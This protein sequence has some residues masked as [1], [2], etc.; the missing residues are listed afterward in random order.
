MKYRRVPLLGLCLVLLSLAGKATADALPPLTVVNHETKECGQIQAADE[1]ESCYPTGDWELLGN[2]RGV[3]CPDGYAHTKPEY[4]C[5]LSKSWYC[6]TEGNSGAP[7]DCEDMIISHRHDQCAF[8]DDINGCKPPRE[9]T[10]QPNGRRAQEWLCPGG[11]EWID[12]LQ[13]I[14]EDSTVAEPETPRGISLPCLGALLVAPILL[15]LWLTS[16]RSL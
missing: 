3:E 1:C 8:V 5:D 10:R 16:R 4:A 12:D 6:C 2:G 14:G 7:G 9:W 15:G 11:Y 13:C